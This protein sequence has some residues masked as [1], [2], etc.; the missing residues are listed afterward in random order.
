MP[1]SGLILN[2]GLQ[3]CKTD[4]PSHLPYPPVT[5]MFVHEFLENTTKKHPEKIALIWGD[6]RLSY[7]ETR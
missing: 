6:Q 7:Q 2:H 3:A 5:R 4:M 1:C